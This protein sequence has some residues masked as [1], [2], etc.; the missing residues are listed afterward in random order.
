M[1]HGVDYLIQ[2][3]SL[4]EMQQA[5]DWRRVTYDAE[6][7]LSGGLCLQEDWVIA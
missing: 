2:Q 3:L 5:V 4:H 1:L 7:V 6:L